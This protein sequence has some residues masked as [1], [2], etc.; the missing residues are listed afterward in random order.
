MRAVLAKANGQASKRLKTRWE[1]DPEKMR[2]FAAANAAKGT[3]KLTGSHFDADRLERH[4][5][6]L[7]GRLQTGKMKKGPKN[8]RA[9]NFA[10]LDPDGALHK[11]RNLLH[12]VRTHSDLFVPR[13]LIVVRGTCNAAKMLSSLRPTLA[14]ARPSWKGWVW[15]R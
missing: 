9:R 8:M 6:A 14:H 10:L 4:S 1:N 11:G 15:S 2:E 7:K 5:A 3:A 13:D 12:F